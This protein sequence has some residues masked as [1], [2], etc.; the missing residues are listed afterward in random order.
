MSPKELLYIDDA[1]GHEKFLISQCRQA[2]Q[3]LTD[4][5]LKDCAQRMLSA[6]QDLFNQ[7]YQLV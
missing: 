7:F 5:V 6:H 3:A 4:P 2:A 1:L